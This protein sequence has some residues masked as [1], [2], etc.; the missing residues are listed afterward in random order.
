MYYTIYKVTNKLDGKSYIGSHKTKKLDDG[1]MGSG[2]YL[3]RSIEKHGLENFEKEI[4][5]V[6]ETADEMYKKEAELVNE[7]FLMN[8]NTYNLKVG[9][10]GGFDYIN[11]KGLTNRSKAGKARSI[12]HKD[13]IKK[14]GSDGGKIRQT[15]Y[16]T[17]KEF[18]EAGKISFLGKHHSEE[19]KEKMRLAK[20]NYIPWNKGKTK[21]TDERLLKLS[22]TNSKSIRP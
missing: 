22:I 20:K 12:K 7:D 4:L 14:W 16:G 18:L 2:K 1:Y 19:T 21:E 5:H 8:E 9:G 10:F 3:K 15:M 17:P 13:S 6:F 11:E